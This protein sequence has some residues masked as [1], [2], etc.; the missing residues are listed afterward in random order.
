M[1]D[2]TLEAII[3]KVRRLT[4]SPSVAQMS[5]DDIKEYVDTFVLY[6]FPEH[7][8]LFTFKTTFTFYTEPNVDVYLP[9]MAAPLLDF[10][11]TYT[12]FLHP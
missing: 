5:D 10:N 1:A 8:R 4:R 9:T 6:D 7:L 11:E 3:K 12:T 2:S